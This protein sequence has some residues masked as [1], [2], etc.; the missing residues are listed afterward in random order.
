MLTELFYYNLAKSDKDFGEYLE[1]L[2]K[3]TFIIL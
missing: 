2:I 3:N 1:E